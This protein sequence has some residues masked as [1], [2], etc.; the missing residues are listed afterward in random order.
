MSVNKAHGD[1]TC[2]KNARSDAE[3]LFS[4]VRLYVTLVRSRA[5]TQSCIIN[6]QLRHVTTV[7]R[8]NVSLTGIA[9]P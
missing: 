4:G 3:R 1:S 5:Y 6:C 8:Y 9:Q 7:R 2:T